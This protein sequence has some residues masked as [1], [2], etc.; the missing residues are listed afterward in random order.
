MRLR[1]ASRF[2][3]WELAVIDRLTRHFLSF[4]SCETDVIEKYRQRR[5]VWGNVYGSTYFLA[6]PRGGQWCVRFNSKASVYDADFGNAS[7]CGVGTSAP[8]ADGLKFSGAFALG[9]YAAVVLSRE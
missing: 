6:L 4:T 9:R 8:G 3:C 7:S 2:E 1:P 5:P